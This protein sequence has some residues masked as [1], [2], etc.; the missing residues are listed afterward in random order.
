VERLF[1]LWFSGQTSFEI[2]RDRN[3]NEVTDLAEVSRDSWCTDASWNCARTMGKPEFRAKR[4]LPIGKHSQLQGWRV[5]CINTLSPKT[6]ILNN[7]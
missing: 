2:A 7:R 4:A 6:I 3:A 5:S 1:A